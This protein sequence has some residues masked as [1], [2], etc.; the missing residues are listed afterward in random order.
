MFYFQFYYLSYCLCFHCLQCSMIH[1]ICHFDEDSFLLFCHLKVFLAN[2][3]INLN[4][5]LPFC[6][7]LYLESNQIIILWEVSKRNKKDQKAN[8]LLSLLTLLEF[9]LQLQT[10]FVGFSS[11]RFQMKQLSTLGTGCV[12]T[13]DETGNSTSWVEWILQPSCNSLTMPKNGSRFGNS[14]LGL[15]FYANFQANGQL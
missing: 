8:F 13:S 5:T 10:F 9:Y 3:L 1:L 7:F 11:C 6:L 14:D 4:H 15:E 12:T 2:I